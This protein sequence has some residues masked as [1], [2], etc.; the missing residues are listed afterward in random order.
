MTR[1]TLGLIFSQFPRYDEAF[2]LREVSALAEGSAEL[3][4]FSLRPCRDRILH[5]QA[6]PFQ[7]KTVYAPFVW[8]VAVWR[9]HVFFLRKSPR[10]YW[11]SLGWII[12][13]HWKH[14]IILLKTLMFFP[15]TVY[16]ARLAQERGVSQLHA[17][18]AT[19]PTSSAM[20]I[21]RLTGIPYSLSGHAHDI[22][23]TNPT[24]VEKMQGAQFVV[25]CTEFNRT[26]LLKLLNGHEIGDRR[27]ETRDK[28][29]GT[30]LTS[31]ISCPVIVSYHG[32]DLGRF[33]ARSK[34][35]HEACHIL[36]VGSL[37][38]CK[39]FETLIEGC[40]TLKDLGVAFH[41]TIAGGGPLERTLRRLIARH[42]LTMHV[43]LTGYVSQD[44]VASLYHDADVFV[45]P[46]VSK[47]HWGI[48]NVVIEAMATKTPVICCSLPSLSELVEHGHSGWVIPEDDPH[49]LAQAVTSLWNDPARRQQLAETAY[50]RVVEKFSLETT[51][52]KLR[53]LFMDA[54]GETGFPSSPVLRPL[55]LA[56]P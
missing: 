1:P 31:R 34:P 39:G 48:P 17:F 50:Q 21:N 6:K 36:S 13:R 32:V 40:K 5:E 29:Q 43:T 28:G 2:L 7:A 53:D 47:I 54:H 41:C 33:A 24:L 3:V 11:G 35:L 23:T 38:P 49:T 46:L 37:F 16:F 25:T 52:Q 26:H 8:S 15:K 44:T 9:S 51:G 12:S 14:P 10:A 20:I 27:Q 18:W 22:Y 30:R 42:G 45:L 56:A 4:I 55:P 19:Y